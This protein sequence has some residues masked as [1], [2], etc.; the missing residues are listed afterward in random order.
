MERTLVGVDGSATA[1]EALKW[2]ADLAGRAQ[3]EVIAAR[4]FT[5]TQS[6]LP[7]S[8]DR[9]M[10]ARQ[11]RELEGWCRGVTGTASTKAV[12]LDGETPDALLGRAEDDGTDL[13]VVGGRDAGKG[14]HLDPAS[15]V[16]RLVHST[17]LP[18]AVVPSLGAPPL[19]HLV[20]GVDG[21]DG[22][23]AALDFATTLAARLQVGITAVLAF[24]PFL[25]FV[26]ETDP[27][28]WRHVAE[29][30]VRRW[31][32]GAEEAGVGVEI[33]VDRDVRPVAA[34]GRALDAHPGSVACVGMRRLSDVTGLRVG[35]IAL[36][37]LD[38]KA[39][40]VILVPAERRKKDAPAAGEP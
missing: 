29:R 6:E 1:V 39:S 15:V 25:E 35:R 30:A 38:R 32:A 10:H 23:L 28:S 34:I 11:L 37:L 22:S 4:V 33:K 20:A 26:P 16:D 8:V 31:V 21:S 2:S 24:E 7:P 3:L 5:P 14:V 40:V 13:V 17:T 18:L 9:A 36:Q 27:Q 12:V 19:G